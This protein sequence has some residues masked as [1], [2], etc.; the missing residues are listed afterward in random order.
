MS[1]IDKRAYSVSQ[2]IADLKL[3]HGSGDTYAPIMRWDELLALLDELEALKLANAAQDDH[4][5]QQQDRIDLLE[6]GN[7]EA[8]RQIN[9]WRRL[10]KQNIA[11]REKDVSE[12]N[13][14]RKRIAEL[15][16]REVVLPQR[17]SMLHRVDFDEP[18]H[19][20]MVYK[21]HQVLEALHDAG[22]NVAAAAKREAS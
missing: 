9:S 14:A 22:V 10:A 13:I 4:T 12:L 7:N 3:K 19:T 1:N 17:Y 18:Y 20:E 11:E 16:A 8:A 21:Q 5:N 15:E 2:I 6:K